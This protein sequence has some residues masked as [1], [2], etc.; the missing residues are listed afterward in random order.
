M[1]VAID[2]LLLKNQNA[3]TGFYAH[4][5]FVALSRLTTVHQSTAFVDALTPRITKQA[6]SSRRK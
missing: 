2:A 3:G 1:R 5:L 4:H 6:S